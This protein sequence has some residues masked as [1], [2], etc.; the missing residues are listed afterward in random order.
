MNISRE[1]LKNIVKVIHQ[2]LYE[3]INENVE[4]VNPD[5]LNAEQNKQLNEM[6][7]ESGIR[8]LSDKNLDCVYLVNNNVAAGLWTSLR[9]DVFSFD[10]IVGKNYRNMALGARIIRQGISIYREI[11]SDFPETKLKLDVVNDRLV[12]PLKKMG[13]KVQFS[14]QGHTIMGYD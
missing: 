7:K 14:G 6:V 2:V 8:I 5:D 13:L 11:L 9:N 3:T 12:G 4:V 1:N 10:T